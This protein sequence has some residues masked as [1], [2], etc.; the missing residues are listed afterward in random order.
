MLEL[1]NITV[2]PNPGHLFESWQLARQWLTNMDLSGF[3]IYPHGEFNATEIPS[4]LVGGLHLKSFPILTPL[5]YNDSAKLLQIFGD[6]PYDG[7]KK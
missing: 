2:N 6:W 5:L 3:E 4:E 1:T 7:D